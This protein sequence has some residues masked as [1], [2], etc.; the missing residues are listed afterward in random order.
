MFLGDLF[1]G[2]REVGFSLA[3]S[4]RAGDFGP[5]LLNGLMGQ[6]NRLLDHRIES[7]LVLFS[8]DLGLLAQ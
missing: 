5:G 1:N 2:L 8:H 4:L 7:L 6:L 3:Q